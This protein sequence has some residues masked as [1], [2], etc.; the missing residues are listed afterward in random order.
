MKTLLKS[1]AVLTALIVTASATAAPSQGQHLAQCKQMINAEFNDVKRIKMAN[2]KERRGTMT[3]KYSVSAD[4]QRAI[5]TCTVE[6]GADTPLLVRTDK[7]V[8]DVAGGQ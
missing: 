6:K 7:S 5:Y 8:Q 3:A 4:G 1:T 2:L